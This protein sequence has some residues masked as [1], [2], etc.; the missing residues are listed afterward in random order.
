MRPSD[1]ELLALAEELARAA[2]RKGWWIA[3]AES[4]TGGWIGMLITSLPGSSNWYDG[5]FITY[6]N[7]AKQEMLG[8]PAAVI[9]THGA[10][11][12]E[13]AREM[14]K[15]A[16]AHSRADAAL[17]VSGI[18]G[19]A[20]ATPG[21]PVGTV[22]MGWALRNGTVLSTT[23]RMGGDRQEVRAR[24]VAAAVRGLLELMK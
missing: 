7:E 22:C 11:S 10:V 17:S 20:G 15:G 24:A 3:T 21:K 19:P 23:C 9:E 13:T 4:C 12:E 16:I 14:A 2:M 18:A 6:S 1:Q 8:V 5:G